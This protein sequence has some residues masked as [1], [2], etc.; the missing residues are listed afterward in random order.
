[1][2]VMSYLNNANQ[3]FYVDGGGDRITRGQETLA[4]EIG[5]SAAL[6]PYTVMAKT[7]AGKWVPLSDV[8]AAQTAAYLTCGARAG[9]LA[10]WQAITDGE[11]AITI[12]GTLVNVLGLNFSGITALS[13]IANVINSDSA[14]TGRF[15]VEDIDGAGGSFRVKSL[16][17]GLPGSSVSYLVAVSGGTGTDISG[18]TT[19]LNGQTGTGVITL[20]TGDSFTGVPAGIYVG[21]QVTASALAAADIAKKQILVAGYPVYVDKNQLVFE[22]SQTLASI[23]TANEIN[24]TVEDYMVDTLG[25]IPMDT[26]E[27][28]GYENA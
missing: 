15:I 1:M 10:A 19:G 7:S 24:K 22:N 17:T 11:F 3:P 14:V 8:D 26:V 16:R 25:I 6:E 28:D 23:I 20:A 12:D 27:M 13:Q 9:A 5:R 2:P 4:Q 21:T 18:G